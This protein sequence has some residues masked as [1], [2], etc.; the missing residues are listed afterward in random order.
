MIKVVNLV[1]LLAAPLMVQASG[2]V[3]YVIAAVLLI[4]VIWAIFQSKKPAQ[5]LVEEVGSAESSAD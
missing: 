2:A 1:S 5:E 3:P 4:A